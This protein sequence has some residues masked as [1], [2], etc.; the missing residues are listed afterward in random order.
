MAYLTLPILKVVVLLRPLSLSGVGRIDMIR[1]YRRP[2]FTLIELL[3]V[4]AIITILMA[5]LVPAV[6]KVREAANKM[7]CG[8]NLKQIGIALHA[9]HDEHG[10]YPPGNITEGA[11]CGTRSRTNW[12]IEILPYMEKNDLFKQYNNS[13]GNYKFAPNAPA[14]WVYNTDAVNRFV[15]EQPV[16][17]YNCP[18]DEQTDVLD[19]PASGPGSGLLYRRGSYRA[20][21][22]RSGGNGRVFWDTCE[23][24]LGT[25]NPAWR[26]ALH[27][28]GAHIGANGGVGP[29]PAQFSSQERI[30]HVLDG[31]SNTLLVGEYTNNDNPRRRSFWAYS[32]TSFNSSSVTDQSRILGNSYWR[33]ATFSGKPG[34][35]DW[36]GP[37]EDNPCKRGFG[38]NHPYGL[39]FVFVDGSVRFVTYT[40]DIN[41]LAA[42]ATINGG[43][44]ITDI[45][46]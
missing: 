18:S 35:N 34:S 36:R 20:V 29:C 10:K 30:A 45:Y 38:S 14:G 9:Y 22:G 17:S 42:M 32:Y 6:Q 5:L 1:N 13:P 43:E 2:A 41:L 8:N 7:S 37:G 15:R 24:G 33:C 23:P 26:G 4:I 25:L 19:L 3:V 46:N 28:T 12:A 27:S 44:A 40:V 39:N 31:T 11:C 21:S 16:R